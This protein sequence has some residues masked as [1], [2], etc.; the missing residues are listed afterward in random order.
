MTK[1]RK[2]APDVVM[3]AGLNVME[4][5]AALAVAT[6]T[7]IAAADLVTGHI[8][9]VPSTRRERVGSRNSRVFNSIK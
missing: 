6:M 7:E 2:F 9:L 3:L 8:C 1:L 4:S 5:R